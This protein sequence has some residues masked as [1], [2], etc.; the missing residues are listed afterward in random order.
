[1]GASHGDEVWK[2]YRRLGRIGP[3]P[4]KV[5]GTHIFY[6]PLPKRLG[7]PKSE[8]SKFKLFKQIEAVSPFLL[9]ESPLDAAVHARSFKTLVRSGGPNRFAAIQAA[10]ENSAPA[11]ALSLIH[12]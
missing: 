12:I 4:G 7:K 2:C 8:D 6:T 3:Y 1:M 5:P 10:G 11:G 9:S